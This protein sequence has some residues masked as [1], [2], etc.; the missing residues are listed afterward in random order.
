MDDAT[1]VQI[2]ESK[3]AL[4]GALHVRRALPRRERRTVGAWCFADHLGPTECGSARDADV[5]PHPHMGLQ[6]VTWLVE[7]EVLHRDS[8][9]SEQVITPGQLNLMTAGSGI[10][11][12]EELT[13]RNQGRVHALQLW[14]AQPDSTRASAP[15]FEHHAELPR[16]EVP[17]AIVTVLVGE[18]L[19]AASVARSDTP[20]VGAQLALHAAALL[21]L[22][23]G[24]EHALIVLDGALEVD[25]RLLL[26][27]RLGFL[28]AGREELLIEAERATAFL[29][30]GEPFTEQIFMWWNFVARSS[31]EIDLAY[32]SW[33]DDDGRFGSVRSTL[34]RIEAKP[35]YWQPAR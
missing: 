33:R 27:G 25:G 6:T 26:P 24:F 17:G 3:D 23:K 5:G 16:V 12:A 10:A 22:D 2:T 19:S 14:I 11:H 21:P 29:L 9:G 32:A 1:A 28:P 35:P 18:V 31:S 20:L 7:G 8:L 15:A 30:G 34:R 4:V 13:G